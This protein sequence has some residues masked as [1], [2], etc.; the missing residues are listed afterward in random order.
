MKDKY[1]VLVEDVLGKY[2]TVAD[3]LTEEQAELIRS[4]VNREP[5]FFAEVKVV[6]DTE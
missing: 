3:G 2:G 4:A 1:K 5:D 6:K